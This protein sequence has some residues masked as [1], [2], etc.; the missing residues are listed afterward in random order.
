MALRPLDNALPFTPERPKRQVKVTAS[1]TKL[2]DPGVNDEN[3][4]PVPPSA[5]ASVDY[6]LSENLSAIP[7]PEVKIQVCRNL[8]I[9]VNI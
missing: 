4:A 9:W 1:V 6:V 5:D 3:K 8:L 7:D 2:P